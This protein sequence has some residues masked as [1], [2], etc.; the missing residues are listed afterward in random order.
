MENRSEGVDKGGSPCDGIKIATTE[1]SPGRSAAKSVNVPFG[2]DASGTVI[3]SGN[4]T[5]NL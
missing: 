1:S 3:T 4:K 2:L 5:S